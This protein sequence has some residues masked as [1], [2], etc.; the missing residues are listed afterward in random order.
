MIR[1]AIP[2]VGLA[3]ALVLP[4]AAVQAPGSIEG[5]V[6][7]TGSSTP[8]PRAKVALTTTSGR[9]V[10]TLATTIDGRFSIPDIAPGEY[11]LGA[12]LDGFVAN[13]RGTQITIVSGMKTN[14]SLGIVQDGAISGRIIDWDGI[15]VV[16]VQVQ[17]LTF[18]QDAR[19]R[20][21]LSVARSAQTN[22]LGE[23]R[24]FWIPPGQ[25][26]VSADTAISGDTPMAKVL[27]LSQDFGQGR[28]TLASSQLIPTYFPRA[29]DA[30]GARRIDVRA[31]ETYSGADIQLMELRKHFVSGVVSVSS[32]RGSTIV[33]LTPRNP[34]SGIKD[35]SISANQMGFFIFGNVVPGGYFLTAEA[36]NADGAETFARMPIDVGDK[37]IENLAVGLIPGFD[38]RI[39]LTIEGRSRR[40]D[41][42][43]LVVNLRPTI[44]DTPFPDVER[45]GNDELTMH[46]VMPGDYSV[47][48]LSLINARGPNGTRVN[49][50][51]YLKSA[52]YGGADVLMTG[53]HI[54]GPP[55]GILGIAMADGAGSLSGSV[56][57]DQKKPV[58]GV[59]IV[60]VPEPRLRGRTDL[61]KTA[62]TDTTGKFEIS[63]IVPGQ[64]KAFS[65]EDVAQGV[66]QYPDFMAMYEDRGQSI[67]I[68][69]DHQDPI[70]VQLIPPRY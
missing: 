1:F 32:I 54:E 14:V 21:I 51:L 61:Y 25:Y 12:A 47:A 53:L 3:A 70:S 52:Q 56:L 7:A 37:D 42:P 36:T 50:R 30:A 62:M 55:T 66:W 6:V 28:T 38:L 31:G 58:T 24:I 26:F 64:Y 23:Y 69:G 17:A 22:D 20:R 57:D 33:Q 35:V 2:L 49:G 29:I 8:V 65:W 41:D 9:Q 10:A 18:G 27:N 5:V 45:N 13:A 44:T 15:P 39:G 63:G 19:G 4:V 59:T 16:G 40:S 43:E 46:H 34:E 68:D 11:R 60:L 67:R 48:V